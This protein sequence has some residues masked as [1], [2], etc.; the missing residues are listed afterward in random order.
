[1]TVNIDRLKADIRTAYEGRDREALERALARID[2]L[3]KA[4]PGAALS[5]R[6]T[7]PE[8]ALRGDL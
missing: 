1:M 5:W 6:C 4:A 3:V 7:C 8:C 2:N